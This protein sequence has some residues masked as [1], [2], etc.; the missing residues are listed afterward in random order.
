MIYNESV[1]HQFVVIWN[2]KTW[3]IMSSQLS[4]NHQSTKI[5]K[6]AVLID[7]ETKVI[8]QSAVFK[9]SQTMVYNSLLQ[10]QETVNIKK[11]CNERTEM[12]CILTVNALLRS[13]VKS[14]YLILL[15]KIITVI[16]P[17]QW[18]FSNFG[19]KKVWQLIFTVFLIAFHSFV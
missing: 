4:T 6:P 10:V 7:S 8:H 16:I 5:H 19:P 14:A 3:F 15:S 1:I 13:I 11:N 9:D 2:L 12:T 18:L 17:H